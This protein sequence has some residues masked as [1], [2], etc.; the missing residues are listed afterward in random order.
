MLEKE[1]KIE[2]FDCRRKEKLVTRRVGGDF[3]ISVVEDGKVKTSY[4]FQLKKPA[5]KFAKK[6]EGLMK[7]IQSCLER[8]NEP[9]SP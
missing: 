2:I 7:E 4:W 5:P 9:T 8:Q 1:S 6:I 3:E